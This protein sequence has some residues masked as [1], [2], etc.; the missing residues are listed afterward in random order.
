MWIDVN[1]CQAMQIMWIGRCDCHERAIYASNASSAQVENFQLQRK[2]HD[3]LLQKPISKELID[4]SSCNRQWRSA[5][6]DDF[7][8]ASDM[9]NILRVI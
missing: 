8:H 3:A 9:K 1:S 5:L 4:T 7:I 2:I 6:C